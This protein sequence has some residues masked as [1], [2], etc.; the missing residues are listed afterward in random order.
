MNYNC[1]TL[2]NFLIVGAAKSGTTSLYRYLNQHSKIFLPSFKEPHFF[3]NKLVKGKIKNLIDDFDIYENLF[4]NTGKY[5]LR[6]EASV[7]Y[8]YYY[9]EA[10]KNIL[11][12]LGKDTK[13]IIILRNPINRAYS[14]YKQVTSGIP[15]LMINFEVALKNDYTSDQNITPM[16]HLKEMGLYYKSVKAYIESFDNVYV[17]IFDDFTNQTE[18]EINNIVE[19]L[20]IEKENLNTSTTHNSERREWKN[21]LAAQLKVRNPILSKIFKILMISRFYKTVFTK[22]FND[23]PSSTKK[24][25]SKYYKTD[26]DNLSKLLQKNLN[27]WTKNIS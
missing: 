3:V 24:Y 14:A 27:H 8:L 2:P 5:K 15:D 20:G 25:L 10:I 4:K 23:M 26:V 21:K 7:F 16:F 6:G 13:I 11:K 22:N 1:K 17:I 9:K 12:T 18:V 19:F